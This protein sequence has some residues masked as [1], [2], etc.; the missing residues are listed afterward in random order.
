MSVPE[1]VE[2]AA[3]IPFAVPEVT[4]ADVAAV[5]A[6]LRSGWLHS[7]SGAATAPRCL[8]RKPTMEAKAVI[9]AMSTPS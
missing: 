4:E 9:T 5:T 6:V 3:P 8:S 7:T 2:D 1:R